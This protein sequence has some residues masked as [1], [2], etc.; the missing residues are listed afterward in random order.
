MVCKQMRAE[1]LHLLMKLNDLVCGNERRDVDPYYEFLMGPRLLKDPCIWA[2][3]ALN[4]GRSLFLSPSTVFRLHLWVY[5]CMRDLMGAR[6]WSDF[7][8]AFAGL[9][10]GGCPGKVVVTLHFF[11]N[12]QPLICE[13]RQHGG[14]ADLANSRFA[15]GEFEI[16]M[17]GCGLG[18]TGI[19]KLFDEKRE[20]LNVHESHERGLCDVA[21]QG[22][23]LSEQLD[24]TEEMA[25]RVV[26][27]AQAKHVGRVSLVHY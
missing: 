16:G 15:Y 8:N 6:G 26:E 17:D 12:Y 3:R 23:R 24:Q 1:T 25:V 27:M 22:G 4:N 14:R 10:N 9:V 5:P 19:V 20:V 21:S 7:E 2:D 13:Y 18:N 11:V